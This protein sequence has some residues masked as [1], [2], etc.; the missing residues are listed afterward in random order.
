MAAGEKQRLLL[1]HGRGGTS[2]HGLLK[3]RT[4][5][6]LSSRSLGL[7]EHCDL[8]LGDTALRTRPLHHWRQRFALQCGLTGPSEA[9]QALMFCSMF[10]VH[11]HQQQP[12][13]AVLR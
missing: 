8:E 3:S 12:Y 11:I 5:D 9:L 6:P 7:C 4:A 1:V 10:N 13:I 2:R